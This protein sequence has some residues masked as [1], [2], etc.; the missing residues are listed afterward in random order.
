MGWTV[1]RWNVRRVYPAALLGW[2]AAGFLTGSAQSFRALLGCRF[3]LGLFEA[4]NWPCALRT[5]QRILRPE[6][7]TLGNGILQS[8]A[9]L[10]AV[11]TPLLVQALVSGPGT[12]PQ[13]F[14]VVGALGSGW[15]V[16]WLLSVRG[17]DLALP[18]ADAVLLAS[19]SQPYEKLR[20]FGFVRVY[21]DRR[22]LACIVIVVSINLTWHFFRVWL[23]LFLQE[24]RGFR[25]SEVQYFTSIYYLATDAGSLASGF[26]TLW[27]ARRGMTVHQS[28]LTLFIFC[29][30]LTL[31]SLTVL[32][33]LSRA[34]LCGV[35]LVVGFGALGLFPIYYSLSQDLTVRHQGKV[36]GA[37]GCLTWLATALMHPLVGEWLDRTKDYS[38]VVAYAGTVPVLGFLALILLWRGR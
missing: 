8:G 20:G 7:R 29:M 14:R 27:L 32:L 23:P 12:W 22:F 11:F 36:N 33:S 28:R 24:D 6:Q 5:T 18:R 34:V 10:G 25:E 37:L 15:V 35:L 16:L 1:D 2:S 19:P 21:A 9:A 38:L 30:I 13:P 31:C 26:G 4:G 17:E 3:M